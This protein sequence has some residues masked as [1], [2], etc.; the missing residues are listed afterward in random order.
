[1]KQIVKRRDC[2]LA[3]DRFVRRSYGYNVEFQINQINL[4]VSLI[5]RSVGKDNDPSVVNYADF[6]AQE[7]QK[8]QFRAVN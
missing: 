4:D 8:P 3:V 5:D 6:I 1:M 7:P 2:V